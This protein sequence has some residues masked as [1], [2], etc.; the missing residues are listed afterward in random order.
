MKSR[1]LTECRFV[2]NLLVRRVPGFKSA[3]HALLIAAYTAVNL[4]IAFSEVDTTSL[5]SVG[6]RFGWYVLSPILN[7]FSRDN[8]TIL[9]NA[10]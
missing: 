2:R 10:Y 8:D 7:S 1:E 9:S 3:G 4:A 6:H 5:G